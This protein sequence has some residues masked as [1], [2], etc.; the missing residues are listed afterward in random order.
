[1][2]TRE[3]LRG[4][5]GTLLLPV[6]ADDSIDYSR[7][8]DELDYLIAAGLD[9]I[10]SNG[11]A[12]EFH[13]QTEQEFDNI[14]YLMAEKCHREGMPFQIGAAHPS[15]VISLERIKRSVSLKPDAFQVILPD[16]VTAN[17]KEQVDYLERLATEASGIPLVL[18]NPPHAKKVLTPA[19]LENLC[20]TIP[21]LIGVKLAGGDKE[22]F[23]AM[24]WSINSFSVFVPGHFLASGLQAKV[25][26]GAYSNV[27]CLSPMGSQSWWKLMKV[28][29]PAALEIQKRILSFFDECIVPFKNAGYSNPAL[30]KLLAA[31]GGWA[32]LGTRLRWPYQWIPESEVRNVA[33]KARS[34][35]P[36]FF[37]KI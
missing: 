27:A 16:W 37:E 22:W 25:A 6:N 2:L 32:E 13:N 17:E 33:L 29:M 4:N 11:T 7:L 31:A 21:Q 26:D 8:A 1:M 30:D 28:D 10:Y 3:N 14:Q 19:E 5:W 12:G 18:Y 36:E 15:P 24:Q 35:L 20:N 23:D 9:G 34:W